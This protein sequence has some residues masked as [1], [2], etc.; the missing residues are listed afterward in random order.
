MRSPGHA[1]GF[2]SHRCHKFLFPDPSSGG[3]P[4]GTASFCFLRPSSPPRGGG[5]IAGVVPGAGV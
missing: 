3:S 2:T 4:P 1:P 5:R